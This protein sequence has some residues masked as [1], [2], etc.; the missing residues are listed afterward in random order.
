MTKTLKRKK[1]KKNMKNESMK[2]VKTENAAF[3]PS[4]FKCKD[5]RAE[6]IQ[7]QGVK[8]HTILKC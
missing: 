6:G 4:N 8:T 3:S 7:I 5:R 1:I 2:F